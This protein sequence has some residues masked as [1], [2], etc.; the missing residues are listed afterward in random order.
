M[1][2]YTLS[3][4][5]VLVAV[6]AACTTPVYL[7]HPS[8]GQVVKCGPYR[9]T[10]ISSIASAEREARCISDYQAQGYVRVPGPE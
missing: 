10:G 4:I 2:I 8:T 3:F 5:V 7:K 9:A 6:L 1:N